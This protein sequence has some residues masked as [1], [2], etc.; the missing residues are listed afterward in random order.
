MYI[1][2]IHLTVTT[3]E[4]LLNHPPPQHNRHKL[5]LQPPQPPQNPLQLIPVAIKIQ[6]PFPIPFIHRHKRLPRLV[7]QRDHLVRIPRPIPRSHDML[8][9]PRAVPVFKLVRVLVRVDP[10]QRRWVVGDG[11]YQPETALQV[12]GFVDFG[13][14]DVKGFGCVRGGGAI[15]VV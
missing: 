6:P 3:Y 5:P 14:V 2:S 1:T 9:A 7:L 12:L 13:V 10:A 4:H 11:G 15:R 8:D